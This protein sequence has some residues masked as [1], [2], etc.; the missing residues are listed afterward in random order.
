MSYRNYGISS[1]RAQGQISLTRYCYGFTL[2]AMIL[3]FAREIN[4]TNPSLFKSSLETVLSDSSPSEFH[5][6]VN[7]DHFFK[8]SEELGQKLKK[9]FTQF[10]IIGVGGSSMGSRA[11]AEISGATNLLFLDNVDSSE[12]AAVWSKISKQ[13]E[14]TAFIVVSKSGSTIEI[15]WNYS[16][17]ENLAQTHFNKSLVSQSFFISE[18]QKN[19]LSDFA[20]LHNR[21]L[22]EA[23]AKVGGRFSVLTP[24]GLIVAE[25]CGLNVWKMKE[26]AKQA[27]E[28]KVLVMQTCELFQR[29]FQRKENISLFWFYNSNFRWFGSW[30]QQLW[31]ESLGKSTD[32]A[33]K[34]APGFS[35]PVIAIGSCDQHSILQQVAHG[36][37]DKF[38]C[39]FN[40]SSVENSNSKVQNVL[41]DE[42][43][44]MQGRSYGEL[45]ASQSKA[46]CEALKQN[47]VS[48]E[49]FTVDDIDKSKALGYLF[50]FFQLVVATLG[51]Q[52]NVNAFDQPGV[53]LG[54]EITLKMLHSKS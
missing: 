4:D 45:I 19:P 41:F 50:M 35:T 17:L 36:P 8:Q 37:K 16:Q 14:K 1:K 52:E 44:F 5:K 51:E 25:I 33:G 6:T 11:I 43:K 32:R 31:A 7:E 34:P 26:G 12:F 13:I 3:T 42:I 39:I 54:K 21:P 30:I 53:A 49:L 23:P 22:L 24:V 46:T 40:F 48:S 9:D 2:K 15:L 20:R 29:S 18:L 28:N 38:V 47:G 10:V 27:L